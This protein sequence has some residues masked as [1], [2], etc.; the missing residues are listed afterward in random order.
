MNYFKLEKDHSAALASTSSISFYTITAKNSDQEITPKLTSEVDSL[1]FCEMLPLVPITGTILPRFSHS[2]I[3]NE[4]IKKLNWDKIEIKNVDG[5]VFDLKENTLQILNEFNLDKQFA[6]RKTTVPWCLESK[7]NTL[8]NK[9]K[10][11]ILSEK[12]V[13]NLGLLIKL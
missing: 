5:T 9:P 6:M 7:L 8:K 2:M 4:T 1:E 11:K 13:Y 10:N 3:Q 12:K